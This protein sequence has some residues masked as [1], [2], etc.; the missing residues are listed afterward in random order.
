MRADISVTVVSYRDHNE[1][2]PRS[3]PSIVHSALSKSSTTHLPINPA[4]LGEEEMWVYT[5]SAPCC[6]LRSH[7]APSLRLTE[8]AR[9]Y[10]QT[11]SRVC[12]VTCRP[13]ISYTLG[14]S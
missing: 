6:Q 8:P 9:S 2:G 4:A 5:H 7:Q 12:S 3:P 14:C 11:A 1:L 10:R 13:G